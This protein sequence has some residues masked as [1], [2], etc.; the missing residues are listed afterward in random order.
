MRCFRPR[1]ALTAL[2]VAAGLALVG[3]GADEDDGPSAT[4]KPLPSEAAPATYS[5]ADELRIAAEE[6]GIPC[7]GR[8]VP[9]NADWSKDHVS[10]QPQ[11]D[12][13]AAFRLYAS[14]FEQNKGLEQAIQL[15]VY[16]LRDGLR[17]AWPGAI[18]GDLWAVFG[19][20]EVLRP[21]AEPVGGDF[22]D[23]VALARDRL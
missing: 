2:V 11:Y 21:A 5:T 23:L 22:V 18:V 13:G 6:A 7:R 14:P 15:V 10:C 9:T 4:T 12:G 19:K 3:C 20:D 8:F 17:P 16:D 1:T